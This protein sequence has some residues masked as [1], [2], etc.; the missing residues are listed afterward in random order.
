MHDSKHAPKNEGQETLKKEKE[1]ND[2]NGVG[3]D[4]KVFENDLC[5][6]QKS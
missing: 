6:C 2:M 4:D 5:Q 3:S 1:L